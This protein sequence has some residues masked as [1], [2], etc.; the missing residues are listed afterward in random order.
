MLAQHDPATLERPVGLVV[1]VGVVGRLDH[2]GQQSGLGQVEL[3]G[4]I[5]KYCL[6]A[7]W[8]PYAPL[9]K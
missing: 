1:G 8:T 2:A 5:P 6:L 4:S 3:F 7:A 9:P